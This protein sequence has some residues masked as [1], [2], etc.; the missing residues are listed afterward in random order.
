MVPFIVGGAALSVLGIAQGNKDMAK[1]ANASIA[2][3][4]ES[5]K[6]QTAQYVDQV[7]KQVSA[8][9]MSMTDVEL[10]GDS[11]EASVI[12]RVATSNIAGNLTTRLQQASEQQTN[13]ALQQARASIDTMLY[14]SNAE[15]ENLRFNAMNTMMGTATGA[16]YGATTGWKAVAG[17]AG[18]AA[19]GAALG[20][21]MK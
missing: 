20:S 13:L 10:K 3:T 21:A 14:N 5:Y 15:L 17:I 12:N 11:F 6:Q 4:L 2:A 19:S 8:T 9:R 1:Q 18:G 16:K 7:S